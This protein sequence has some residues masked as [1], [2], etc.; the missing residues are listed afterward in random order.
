MVVLSKSD[1]RKLT[2]IE[3][4]ESLAITLAVIVW[5]SYLLIWLIVDLTLVLF[6]EL[7]FIQRSR[8]NCIVCFVTKEF[9]CNF[10]VLTLAPW[11]VANYYQ[12]LLLMHKG[13]NYLV[14]AYISHLLVSPMLSKRSI[15]IWVWKVDIIYHMINQSFN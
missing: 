7:P 2:K 4:G 8:K 10:Y 11:G 1:L 3:K 5:T 12:S 15:F 13:L 14:L 9:R 6:K